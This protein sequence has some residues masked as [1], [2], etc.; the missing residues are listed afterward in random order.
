MSIRIV[1]AGDQPL[2]RAGLRLLLEEK[3][4]TVVGDGSGREALNMVA[5]SQPD[6]AILNLFTPDMHGLE[7]AREMHRRSAPTGVIVTSEHHDDDGVIQTPT[8]Y[9]S[10][11]VSASESQDALV[12]AISEVAHGGI[13]FCEGWRPN[14]KALSHRQREVFKF[15][16]QGRPVKEI[17]SFLGLSAKTVEVHRSRIMDKLKIKDTAHLVRYAIRHGLLSV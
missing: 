14:T 10:G 15:I 13:Y 16:A 11:Y 12:A 4:F 1:I 17:A 8:E 5:Y 7:L 9:F 6:V 2:F 3:G